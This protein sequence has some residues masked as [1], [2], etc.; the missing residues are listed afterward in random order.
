MID[1]FVTF[2]PRPKVC[3]SL[4]IETTQIRVSATLRRLVRVSSRFAMPIYD[5]V[6]APAAEVSRDDDDLVLAS[7]N[8]A[9][10]PRPTRERTRRVDSQAADD[11]R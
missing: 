6:F 5:T 1:L 2:C 4:P 7:D 9:L 11:I 3:D 8:T 10:L